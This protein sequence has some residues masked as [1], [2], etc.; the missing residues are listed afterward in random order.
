MMSQPGKRTITIQI[1]SN[2][3]RFND[4]QSHHQLQDALDV[5]LFKHIY[6]WHLE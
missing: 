4:N 6:F 2:I 1:L 5:D 3:S